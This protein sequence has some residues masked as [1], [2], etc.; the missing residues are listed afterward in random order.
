M[1]HPVSLARLV[2]GDGVEGGQ[3]A[4]GVFADTVGGVPGG[5]LVEEIEAGFGTGG[6]AGVGLDAVFE[7]GFEGGVFVE[8][9]AG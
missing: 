7:L 3:S 2:E 5:V 6:E 1:G 9:F 4:D 8:V